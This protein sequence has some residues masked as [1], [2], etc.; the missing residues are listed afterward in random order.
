MIS[1]N[2]PRV[3][4]IFSLL[5]GSAEVPARIARKPDRVRELVLIL[6]DDWEEFLEASDCDAYQQFNKCS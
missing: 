6:S 2:P 1:P 5:S 3:K 4:V